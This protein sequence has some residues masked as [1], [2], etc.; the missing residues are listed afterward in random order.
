MPATSRNIGNVDRNQI[1]YDPMLARD[2]YQWPHRAM[3]KKAVIIDV[4]PRLTDLLALLLRRYDF[5]VIAAHDGLTGFERVSREPPDLVVMDVLLPRIRGHELCWRM[6][7]D[8]TLAK[9]PV[10]VMSAVYEGHAYREQAHRAGADA[11]LQKPIEPRVFVEKVAKLVGPLPRPKQSAKP[12]HHQLWEIRE[13]YEKDLPH[14]VAQIEAGWKRAVGNADRAIL[15]KLHIATH[16]VVGTTGSLG[17]PDVAAR[18]K[19]FE[20]FVVHLMSG[21]GPFSIE[22]A[23]AGDQLLRAVKKELPGYQPRQSEPPKPSSRAIP[24][25]VAPVP[26]ASPRAKPVVV[27]EHDAELAQKLS[28]VLTQ[29]GYAPRV[30]PASVGVHETIAAGRIKAVIVDLAL[31]KRRGGAVELVTE[32]RS[33]FPDLPP[34]M[35]VAAKDDWQSRAR[36]VRAGGEAFIPQPVDTD[37]LIDDLGGLTTWADAGPFR[38]LIVADNPR[39]ADHLARVLRSTGMLAQGV[40]SPAHVLDAMATLLPDVIVVDLRQ[41]QQGAVEM[42]QVLR[43]HHAYGSI[44]FVMLSLDS[45]IQAQVGLVGTGSDDFVDRTKGSENLAAVIRA[46]ARRARIAQAF[47]SQDSLTGLLS[48]A[49]TMEELRRGVS[50]AARECQELCFA[51]A[52]LDFMG[53]V[54]EQHGIP[55]GDQVILGFGRLLRERLRRTDIVGRLGSDG[56][57]VVLPNTKAW[58]AARVLDEVRASFGAQ[59]FKGQN[60]TFSAT[61]T[62]GVAEFPRCED[63]GSLHDAV[64]RALQR[65]KQDGRNRIEIGT[66]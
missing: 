52:D 66:C 27:V 19:E 2:R 11:F 44:P 15:P 18:A 17:L 54:N 50:R 34:V 29:F 43:Q 47:A 37:R 36:A 3:S 41:D 9:V 7:Q 28:R 61:V 12:L 38:I 31:P 1:G 22:E 8:P 57:G 26:E 21:D 63:V 24:A 45:S 65:A 64:E 6:K 5:D 48:H 35:F 23:Q 59:R 13:S 55:A 51:T 10:I 20:L 62:I 49:R 14:K 46:R 42:V 39:G 33:Q 32:L 60:A 58:A 56:F 40:T 4:E 30:F 25:M 16:S 53:Q